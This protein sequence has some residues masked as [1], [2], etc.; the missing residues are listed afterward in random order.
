M[1]IINSDAKMRK[2]D[3]FIMAIVLLI[4]ILGFLGYIAYLRVAYDVPLEVGLGVLSALM[5]YM[6]RW[7]TERGNGYN[8]TTHNTTPDR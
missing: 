7:I 1:G 5:G 6:L 8:G 3:R 4:I 2:R